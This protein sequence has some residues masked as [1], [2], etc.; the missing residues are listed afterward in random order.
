MSET[1]VSPRPWRVD[2]DYL[3]DIQTADGKDIGTVWSDKA[4]GMNLTLRGPM[5]A[6][7][8]A[9]AYANAAFI[10][11]AVNNHE[12]LVDC[13]ERALAAWTGA[14]PGIVLDDLRAAL[15][16]AKADEQGGEGER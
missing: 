13:C 16:A 6:T 15:A 2:P 4:I 3:A 1:K 8:H 12:R 10:V 11:R 14:G 5:A 7:S 9:E